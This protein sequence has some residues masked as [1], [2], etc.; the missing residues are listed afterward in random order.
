[1][2][3]TDT[4]RTYVIKWGPK[5][6]HRNSVIDHK[7]KWGNKFQLYQQKLCSIPG[8]IARAVN[9][10]C[11]MVGQSNYRLLP[12]NWLL[13]ADGNLWPRGT[14]GLL[15]DVNEI[16]QLPF[17]PGS[18]RFFNVI[19]GGSLCFHF[20]RVD[21]VWVQGGLWGDVSTLGP[22]WLQCYR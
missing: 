22:N 10:V 14:E 3:H 16:F 4:Q 5:N 21:D 1:M 7:W 17:L 6:N 15:S 13:T 8:C 9:A 12:T 18:G 19:F 20:V 2:P 11:R